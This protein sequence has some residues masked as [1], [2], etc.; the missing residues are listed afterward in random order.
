M[1]LSTTWG[2][3]GRWNDKTLVLFDD[4]VCGLKD[5]T[6]LSDMELQLFEPDISGNMIA[7]TWF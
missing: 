7:V 4:F 2:H 5:G 1:I 3:P 6:I